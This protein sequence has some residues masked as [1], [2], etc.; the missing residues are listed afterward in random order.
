MGAIQDY[1]T[2]LVSSSKT[3]YHPDGR[4]CMTRKRFVML[5]YEHAMKER[6]YEFI[7]IPNIPSCERAVGFNILA[8]YIYKELGH[9]CDVVLDNMVEKILEIRDEAGMQYFAHVESSVCVD[10]PRASDVIFLS[11]NHDRI[12]HAKNRVKK[13]SPK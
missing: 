2:N 11:K 8:N 7:H 4:P 13:I 3:K 5:C 1:L 10:S 6:G 9:E 12:R